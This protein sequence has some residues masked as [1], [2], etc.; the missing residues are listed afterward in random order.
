MTSP[1]D[2]AAPSAE[3]ERDTAVDVE[4]VAE[5]F[6]LLTA[7]ELV[8]FARLADDAANAPELRARITLSRMAAADLDPLTG[9]EAFVLGL[10]VDR[11]GF[12]DLTWQFRE[13]LAEIDTRTVPRDW[14]E[15]LVRTYIG[16]G[17]F[18]DLERE[19]VSGLS[20][21][22][23][24]IGRAALSD[25]SLTDVCI[26][27][28][29][30]AIESDPQLGARLALWGRRVVGEAL[31]VASRLLQSRPVL[32][33]L[34]GIPVGAPGAADA[35]GSVLGRLTSEHARRMRRLDLTA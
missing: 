21:E 17:V 25:G 23:G 20:G 24:Q 16:Y 33:R 7:G 11:G 6:A 26:A 9:L 3:T 10:G 15:R 30:P 32:A 5:A 29:R 8:A 1:A 12:D 35:L 2:S 31:G 34:V 28:L 13:L 18:A 22:A 4:A 27:M 19:V 14:W